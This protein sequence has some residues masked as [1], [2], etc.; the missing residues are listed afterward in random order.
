MKASTG[1]QEEYIYLNERAV[2]LRR[3]VQNVDQG[4]SKAH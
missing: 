4:S 3:N 2:G 1:S